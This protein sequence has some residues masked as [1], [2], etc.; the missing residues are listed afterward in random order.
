V[1]Y[2]HFISAALEIKNFYTGK[3]IN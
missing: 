3:G 2:K 1:V